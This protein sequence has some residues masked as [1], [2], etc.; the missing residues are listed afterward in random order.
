LFQCM[1]LE[2]KIDTLSAHYSTQHLK[3]EY[4]RLFDVD[5]MNNTD[6]MQSITNYETVSLVRRSAVCHV[7][8]LGTFTVSSLCINWISECTYAF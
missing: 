7:N 5:R 4:A 6:G 1:N 3:W 8:G 2:F